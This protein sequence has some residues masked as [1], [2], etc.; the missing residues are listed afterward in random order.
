MSGTEAAQNKKRV[1]P[2]E[3]FSCFS[4]PETVI[5][6]AKWREMLQSSFYLF[7]MFCLLEYQPAY[8]YMRYMFI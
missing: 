6:N 1:L 3:K 8:N 5:L 4:N 7:R 2:R